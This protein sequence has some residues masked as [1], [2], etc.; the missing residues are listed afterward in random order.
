MKSIIDFLA[1]SLGS[2]GEEPNIALAKEIVS[3]NNRNAIKDLIANLKNKDKNIQSDCIKTLYETGY[4]K[5]ELIAGYYSEFLELLTSKNNRLVWGGMIAIS[6]ITDLRPKEIFKSLD[7]IIK[8]LDK[9]SVITIDAGIEI[10][11]KLN[12]SESFFNTTDPLLSDQLWKCPIKQLPMYIEKSL[13]SICKRNK[14]AYLNI[15]LK[16][17]SECERDSQRKRL[18]SVYK[19]IIKIK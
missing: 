13:K 11:S 14:E 1:S 7:V 9:G 6:T 8:T 19:K 16:R 10:L 18:D 4:I 5:P 2:K 15:I 12:T 3:S 17:K